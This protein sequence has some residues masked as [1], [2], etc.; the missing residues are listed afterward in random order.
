MKRIWLGSL[1]FFFL[2]LASASTNWTGFYLGATAGSTLG[3]FN[4]QTSTT[5]GPVLD[6]IQ[7]AEVN[8]IG[9]QNM[10]SNGFLTGIE[11][12]YNWQCN[13][14]LFGFESDIQSLSLNASDNSGAIL[15]PNDP[16]SHF[17]VSSY[18]NSN[19][20]F[21]ARPRIG[22]IS[23]NCLIYATGG[24]GLAYLQ[25]DF[26]FT[27]NHDALE[28]RR[29]NQVKPGYVVGAG[30]EAG[31]TDH[32]SFKAEYLFSH[33]SETNAYNMNHDILA[34]Q[35]FSNSGS[36]KDHTIRV[37]INYHFSD[38]PIGPF[39]P[40]PR[41]FSNQK[42]WQVE[43][44]ARPWASTGYIGAPQPL[45]NGNGTQLISRLIYKQLSSYSGETFARVDHA[46]GIF[47][48]GFLGAGTIS[49]GVLHDEDF[50]AGGA[51]SNTL[52]KMSG[53]LSYANLDLGYTFINTSNGKT[54]AFVGYNY[55]AQNVGAYS[56][57]Q[58]AG[59]LICSR[60]NAFSRF[61]GI[62]EEDKFKSLRVGLTSQF[63]LT[64]RLSLI[65]EAAYLPY[66]NFT[67]QD[68][69]NARELII[70][71]KSTNDGD[72]VMLE[73]ILNYQLTHSWNIGLGGR[74]W[75]WNMHKG[76]VN[77]KFLGNDE[78]DGTQA[79][80]FNAERYGVFL[81]ASYRAEDCI[82][83]CMFTQ[84]VNWNGIFVGGHVGGGWNT[85]H[86]SNPFGSTLSPENLVNVAGFGNEIHSTGPL[87]GG[88]IFINWQKGCFVYGIGSRI[89]V[90]DLR[91]ENTLFS[92][93]GGINGQATTNYIGTLVGRLGTAFNRSLFY[94][95]GGAAVVNSTYDL[96]GNTNILNLGAEN[97]TV[98]Q[99]GWT[100][101]TGIEYALTNHWTTSFEYNYIAAPDNGLRFSAINTV[102]NQRIYFKQ[103]M[104]LFTL[105]VNYRLGC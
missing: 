79:A 28:S 33:F 73:S 89:S 72:G 69:H 17:V 92:G 61:L 55:Y 50:P 27:N 37:G 75:V 98:T 13:K 68:D 12:G 99:W 105:N 26:L 62:A 4:T 31:L 21:T 51:Y 85:I 48:K 30:V 36:L 56:C 5:E 97:L 87:G 94:I 57:K 77:F 23:N 7:A 39:C 34:G 60:T 82:K 1:S 8:R 81:Q 103:A 59:A 38:T 76:S 54:G 25:N 45:L 43:I 2:N 83:P 93:L 91:G 3:Y 58:V 32:I 100:V 44:G 46:C 104:N 29:V 22:F 102:N 18:A 66:I 42:R 53:N 90:S 6:A 95:N 19:W 65:S 14:I 64:D 20:L 47:A 16:N 35:T 11:G 96:N 71:E 88:N 41:F 9:N 70:T 24:L 49:S 63:A 101:G 10:H 52:S 40:I 80:R 86:V 84:P 78:E 15:Y 74:Y 67:G